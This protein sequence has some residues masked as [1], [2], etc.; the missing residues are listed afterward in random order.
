MLDEFCPDC[1]TRRVALFRYCKQCGLDFD[2]LDVRG[3][4]PYGP[5]TV[6]EPR[7]IA[8]YVPFGGRLLALIGRVR[9][10]PAAY[11]GRAA[12]LAVIVVAI[13]GGV[14]LAG[15]T[16]P[17]LIARATV[18]PAAT[19]SIGTAVVASPS[20]SSPA[21][22]A[23][24][25][26][27]PTETGTVER[28]VD[29][30]TII[31]RIGSDAVRVRYIGMDAPESAIPDSPV[32]PFGKEASKENAALVAGKAVVLEKDVSETDQ[33]GR[34]L[35]NVW[36]QDGDAWVLVGERLVAEGYAQVSTF[37]PDVKYESR[38]LVAQQSAQA[39]AAGL[40]GAPVAE[41]PQTGATPRPTPSLI[42]YTSVQP[43][44]A[45]V[46]EPVTLDGGTG[47][48][49][50]RSVSFDA[51]STRFAWNVKS[52]DP[53]GCSFDWRLLASDGSIADFGSF[54]LTGTKRNKGHR[55]LDTTFALGSIAVASTCA[56]WTLT[57]EG[58]AP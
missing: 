12:I 56:R 35:R 21:E 27:G 14:A 7:S 3:V 40:W 57:F 43:L 37:P 41:L 20:P 46:G 4:L 48:T 58:I 11:L 13:V 9:R 16:V 22:A 38:L 18:S 10:R 26:T 5:Y 24:A 8:R 47:N 44:I 19:A 49:T 45:M 50:W 39:T 53:S 29:G 30:D 54:D 28:V 36:V 55:T 2:E 42:A 17:G 25:P 51:T 32:E 15:N 1:G 33:Y 23:F 52:T 34:L 31:V 6:R